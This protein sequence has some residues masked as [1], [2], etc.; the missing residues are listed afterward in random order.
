LDTLQAAMPDN[1][2]VLFLR[3][4]WLL[5]SRQIDAALQVAQRLVR[6]PEFPA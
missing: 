4:D 2:A 6:L 5:G 1:G 3:A